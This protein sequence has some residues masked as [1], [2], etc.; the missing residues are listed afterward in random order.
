MAK[1]ITNVFSF[2][3]SIMLSHCLIISTG[4]K[5]VVRPSAGP[6]KINPVYHHRATA[7]GF[8]FFFSL[9]NKKVSWVFTVYAGYSTGKKS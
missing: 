2:N 4:E 7:L 5:M 3:F 8:F 1:L 9:L 6:N